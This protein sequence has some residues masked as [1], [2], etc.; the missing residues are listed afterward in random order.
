[1]DNARLA[2]DQLVGPER[3]D[4]GTPKFSGWAQLGGRT[5]VDY[6][7]AQTGEIAALKQG[8]NM[9]LES[10]AELTRQLKNLGGK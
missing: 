3:N 6:L 1:M 9:L 5:V 4:D 8:M 2:L 7:V 10:N